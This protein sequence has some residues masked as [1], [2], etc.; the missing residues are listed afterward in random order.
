MVKIPLHN[1]FEEA[2]GISKVKDEKELVKL[3]ERIRKEGFSYEKEHKEE[4][5]GEREARR[6]DEPETNK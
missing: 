1:L 6:F 5:E 3:A 4:I 2:W